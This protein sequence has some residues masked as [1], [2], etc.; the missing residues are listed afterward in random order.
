VGVLDHQHPRPVPLVQLVEEGGEQLLAGAAGGQQ[1]GQPAAGLAG[2]VVQGPQRPGGEQ[3]VAGP[4]QEPGV[5]RLALG[6]PPDQRRLP[7]AGLA[8]HQDDAASRRRRGQ[9]AAQL[10]QRPSA[11]EQ[12][13]RRPTLP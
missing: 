5:G 2:D 12:V 8:R 7:Q 13:H 6:E 3:R 11:L 4:E 1:G 9:R 10:L